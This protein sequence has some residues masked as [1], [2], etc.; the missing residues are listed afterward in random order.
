MNKVSYMDIKQV[1]GSIV[2]YAVLDHGD[3]S[4]TSMTKAEYDLLQTQRNISQ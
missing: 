1:D 4:F 2:T 3:G